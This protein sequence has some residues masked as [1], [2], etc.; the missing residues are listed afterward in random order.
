MY[1]VYTNLLH[2]CVQDTIVV[3]P[4]FPYCIEEDLHDVPLEDC[5]CARPQLFFTCVMRPKNGRLPKDKRCHTGPDDIVHT[6]V[7]FSTFEELNLPM[8]GPMEDSGSL[9]SHCFWLVTLLPL[10]LTCLASARKQASP[11]AVLTLLLWTDDEAAMSMKSTRGCGRLGAA[12]PALEAC[13]SSR[14]EKKDAT[15][16]ARHKQAAETKRARKTA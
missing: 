7:F 2:C 9:L 6:L 5:W 16:N 10:S 1:T 13:L 3:V 11:L 4:P 14:L 15:S 8:K 12:S